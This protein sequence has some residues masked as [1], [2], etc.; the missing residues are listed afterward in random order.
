MPYASAE[1]LIHAPIEVVWAVMLD[2]EAY[3]EWNPFIVRIGLPAGRP[4]QEGDTLDLH[5]RWRNG[6][7]TVAHEQVTILRP[8]GAADGAAALL[9]YAFG[10][11]LDRLGMVT[12]L[13][14]Q[15]LERVATSTTRYRTE[16]T[17]RGWASRFT[18]IAKVQDG[19]ERHA[20]ALK[21]RAE[22]LAP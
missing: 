5:V 15:R 7:G 21:T 20:A 14:D 1:V 3:P 13:R 17:L 8:P 10:G 11:P 6:K 16:E 19:F 12:G 22:A 18:P 2:T 4:P 9:Q